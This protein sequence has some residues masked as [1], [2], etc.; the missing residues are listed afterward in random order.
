MI[1]VIAQLLCLNYCQVVAS[2]DWPEITKYA[3]LVSS[4][5]HRQELITDLFKVRSDPQR[6]TVAGGMIR[7]FLGSHLGIVQMQ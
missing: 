5:A 4:Q 6:G 7:Y 1:N 2:Q 3:G